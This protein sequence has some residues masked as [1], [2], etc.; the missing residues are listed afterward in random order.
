MVKRAF[1]ESKS[2]PQEKSRDI[3]IK[4]TKLRRKFEPKIKQII[5]SEI[6]QFSFRFHLRT[7]FVRIVSLSEE[8]L[9]TIEQLIR[10]NQECDGPGGSWGWFIATGLTES[11]P[12]HGLTV[13]LL[14][15][16]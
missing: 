12:L 7:P 11:E 14:Y 16:R 1:V 4:V 6:K 3:P 9:S 5:P 10:L 15:G 13:I 8:H 2:S